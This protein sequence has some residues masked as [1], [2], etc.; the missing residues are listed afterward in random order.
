MPMPLTEW[1]THDMLSHF[2]IVRKLDGGFFP[3]G[4]TSEVAQ[5][6]N[7]L[8][9]EGRLFILSDTYLCCSYTC[10]LQTCMNFVSDLVDDMF[11][12]Q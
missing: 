8:S 1:N 11:M 10:I 6:S 2:S 7:V 9:F 4:F 5:G 3:V 12:W